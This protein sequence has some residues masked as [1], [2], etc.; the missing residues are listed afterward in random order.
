M[1]VMGLPKV[2]NISPVVAAQMKFRF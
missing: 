1:N 2:G